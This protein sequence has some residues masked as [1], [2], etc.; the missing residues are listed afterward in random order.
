M[1]RALLAVIVSAAS[2]L[3]AR[4]AQ[5]QGQTQ[6]SR[7]ADCHF[8]N[9]DAPRADHLEDWDRSPH[10]HQNVGCE[11]CHG[12]DPREFEPLLA[13]RGIVGP[14][15]PT[16]PVNRRNLP[17]TCGGCHVGPF[18]AFQDSQHYKLLE[19][20]SEKGPTCS[21]CHGEVDGRLLSPKALASQ[22]NECHGPHE[23]APR[24]ER[25][26][27]AREQYESLAA[28]R[29]EMKLAQSLI[30]RVSDKKRRA[31]LT[32]QYD[33]AQVPLTRAINAGHQ[34]VYDDLREYLGLA[35]KRAEA[36]LAKLANR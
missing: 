4:P 8:A 2:L 3:T 19:S 32:D 1:R 36:L 15:N 6:Q 7:C 13:H 22:C 14:G 33:Q 24:A 17:T 30:K 23:V 29:E 16:S 31:E 10:G 12:G 25:A 28:V 5:G 26:Q 18:V 21:T 20:G 35:Q 27:Q 11:K 9:P 34:F